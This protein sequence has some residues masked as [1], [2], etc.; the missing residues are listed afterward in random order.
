L[1]VAVFLVRV[2]LADRPGALGAV[3][4]RIG[5]VRGDVVGVE[6]IERSG[7]LAVDEFVVELAD[8][9][10]VALLVSE[11]EQV[12]GAAVE[13]VRPLP[14]GRRDRRRD[15]YEGARALVTAGAP[16]EVLSILARLARR[17]LDASWAAVVELGTEGEGNVLASDG[18]V[19]AARWLASLA[20]E[21]R[22]E[23]PSSAP[24]DVASAEL[25]S[26]DL[27]LVIGRPS[28]RFGGNEQLRLEA[29]ARLADAR[30]PELARGRPRSADPSCVG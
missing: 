14:G 22:S 27:H 19:P 3:A 2:A 29:L 26:W 20:T 10:H 7:G 28:W 4:S 30:W 21:V 1:R 9:A 5:A 25:R 13:L 23:T 6:I 17:E 15:A 12:D 24:T 8:E 11:V 18:H 16:E